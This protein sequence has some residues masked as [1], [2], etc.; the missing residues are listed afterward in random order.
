L[1]DYDRE[2]VDPQRQLHVKEALAN[3]NYLPQSIK[4]VTNGY[5]S[6]P[7]FTIDVIH[8]INTKTYSFNAD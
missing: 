1:Y 2:L 7:H 4:P 8:N 3:I 5:L 6:T